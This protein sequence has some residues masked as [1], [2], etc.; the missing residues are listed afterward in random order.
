M[1][2]TLCIGISLAVYVIILA[3]MRFRHKGQIDGIRFD[4]RFEISKRK[5]A[6]EKVVIYEELKFENDKLIREREEATNLAA[7]LVTL[8]EKLANENAAHDFKIKG[9]EETRDKLNEDLDVCH[10]LL[11]REIMR[12]HCN[13]IA[14]IRKLNTA[15]ISAEIGVK[16]G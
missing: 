2:I 11:N 8:I 9:L 15:L 4:L 6:E 16:H 7:T 1:E 14:E 13:Q 5:E 12:K 3:Y 10:R